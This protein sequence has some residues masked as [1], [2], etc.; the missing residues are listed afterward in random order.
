MHFAWKWHTF[1]SMH[2]FIIQVLTLQLSSEQALAREKEKKAHTLE[3]ELN[4]RVKSEIIHHK[5]PG[6]SHLI[7]L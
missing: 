3:N 4:G 6:N 1:Q 2:S 5:R 7:Q